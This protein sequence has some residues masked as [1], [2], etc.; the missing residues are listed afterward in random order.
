[1]SWIHIGGVPRRR[2][3]L[4]F[5]FFFL[6]AKL[7]SFPQVK[8]NF[9]AWL[10]Y[11]RYFSPWSF[12]IVFKQLLPLFY[13]RWLAALNVLSPPS[14]SE[15]VLIILLIFVS[16]VLGSGLQKISSALLDLEFPIK[17]PY[18]H[19]YFFETVMIESDNKF[20]CQNSEILPDNENSFSKA[21]SDYFFGRCLF[22]ND[23]SRLSICLGIKFKGYCKY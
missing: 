5:W 23:R 8:F 11:W 19:S 21:V 17:F 22:L 15:A 13:N 7:I 18:K 1:M 2:L 20:I 3:F 4:L 12:L 14:S 6:K 10:P 16:P 9:L